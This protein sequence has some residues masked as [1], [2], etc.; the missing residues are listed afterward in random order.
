MSSQGATILNR[1]HRALVV[2]VALLAPLTLGSQ[3]TFWSALWLAPLALG[4]ALLDPSRLSRPGRVF[5]LAVLLAYGWLFLVFWLQQS[6]DH[7]R[8]AI[9]DKAGA[10]LGER[11]EGASSPSRSLPWID[12]LPALL[13]G[14]ALLSGIGLG[15]R[16]NRGAGRTNESG[17]STVSSRALLTFV[18]MTGAAYA[19]LWIGLHLADPDSV[20]WLAKRHHEGVMTGTFMNRNVAAAF[21][22][23]SLIALVM[24]LAADMLEARLGRPVLGR[25]RGARHRPWLPACLAPVAV[26]LLMSG[27]RAGL[28]LGVG[29]A[30]MGGALLVL[31]H[32]AAIAGVYSRPAV[33]VAISGGLLCA[34]LALLAVEGR[35]AASEAVDRSRFSVYLL[36]WRAAWDSWVLGWG[37][38]Q[39]QNVFPAFRD[40]SVGGLSV[41]DRAH[42]S[43][44]QVAFEAGM[45]MLAIICAI[46]AAAA[47]ILFKQGMS[48]QPGQGAALFGFCVLIQPILHSGVDYPVQIPGYSIPLLVLIGVI[49]A[50]GFEHST[51]APA[52]AAS[53]RVVT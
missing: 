11:L 20:L 31:R 2:G 15:L 6:P 30:L 9:W 27:S 40:G 35:F 3:E 21:L 7:G 13:P 43:Y 29:C 5:V 44:V 18:G 42:N 34:V 12:L 26:A 24:L 50:R 19:V 8:A 25:R 14:L 52:A 22:G 33:L 45:P 39:F 51:A 48:R 49:M 46:V 1:L 28:M 4:A 16:S 10:A 23:P 37:L 17:V 53:Q 32:A 41:W 47:A 38:G 36:S